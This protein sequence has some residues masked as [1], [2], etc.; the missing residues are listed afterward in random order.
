MKKPSRMTDKSEA[1][2]VDIFEQ[3]SQIGHR[4]D[5][6]QIRRQL[7]C[8]KDGVGKLL[9]E[10]DEWSTAYRSASYAPAW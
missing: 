2:L 10:P 9:F 3:G 6:V 5:P 1:Y 8:E 4:A 7:Q